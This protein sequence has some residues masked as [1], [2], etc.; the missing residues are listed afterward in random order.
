MDWKGLQWR[1][2]FLVFS[3]ILLGVLGAFLSR[4][5]ASVYVQKKQ[6]EQKKGWR[7]RLQPF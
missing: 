2:R 3:G 1:K 5:C 4:V 6:R 7:I